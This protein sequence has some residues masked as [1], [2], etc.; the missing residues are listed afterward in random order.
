MDKVPV[1][2]IEYL[3]N[4]GEVV[5][6]EIFNDAA[7]FEEAVKDRNYY[8]VPMNIIIYEDC[9][10]RCIKYDFIFHLEPITG[11]IEFVPF[12]DSELETAKELI[13]EYLISEFQEFKEGTFD[14]LESVGLAYTE[15]EDGQHDIEVMADLVNLKISQLVDGKVS[16]EDVFSSL[17]EMNEKALSTLEFGE[18]TTI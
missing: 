12:E 6:T 16:K 2:V 8:G 1:G 15:T 4:N 3:G 17:K 5:E 11:L 7:A 14:N 18:L 13:K 10:G 9:E